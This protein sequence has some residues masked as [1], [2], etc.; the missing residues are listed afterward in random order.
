M[1][2][3]RKLDGC[4]GATRG[5]AA[6]NSWSVSGDFGLEGN[7]GTF[8]DLKAYFDRIAADFAVFDI[9][10]RAARQIEDH[11][12]TFATVRA[13][14]EVFLGGEPVVVHVRCPN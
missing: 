13:V 2:Q 10:L 4:D 3:M 1:L 7:E 11:G 8:L 5:N 6:K 9:S 14:E 12:N